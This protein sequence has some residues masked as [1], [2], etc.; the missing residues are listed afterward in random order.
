M[1]VT[2]INTIYYKKTS[3]HMR[4]KGKTIYV[5]VAYQISDEKKQ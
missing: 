4:K 1:P 2:N 5:Q 3:F